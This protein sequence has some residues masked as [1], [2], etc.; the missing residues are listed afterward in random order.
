MR[1]A[2]R[3]EHFHL[4]SRVQEKCNTPLRLNLEHSPHDR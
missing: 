2:F 4:A 3:A 1:T